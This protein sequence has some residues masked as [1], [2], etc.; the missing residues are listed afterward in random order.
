VR[1]GVVAV[2]N[3]S[4]GASPNPGWFNSGQAA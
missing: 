2:R 4:A 3:L 1:T